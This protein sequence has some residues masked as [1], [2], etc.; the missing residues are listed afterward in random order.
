MNC[1]CAHSYFGTRMS[2]RGQKKNY[3]V[4]FQLFGK[5][6]KF[7]LFYFPQSDPKFTTNVQYNLNQYLNVFTLI[8]ATVKLLQISG[9]YSISMLQTKKK[10]ISQSS[11]K[12]FAINSPPS[13][14]F[15]AFLFG[16]FCIGGAFST[17]FFL[18]TVKNIFQSF[19]LRSFVRSHYRNV[20]CLINKFVI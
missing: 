7:R 13:Y 2:R 17:T 14:T 12:A 11:E 20:L 3:F 15:W 10:K 4:K 9:L 18:Y 8:R 16:Y 19:H 1:S 5:F 6:H